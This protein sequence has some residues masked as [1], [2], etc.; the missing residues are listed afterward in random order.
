[1]AVCAL[2]V[3]LYG[4]RWLWQRMGCVLCA[5]AR[6]SL[7]LCGSG[8]VHAV[9]CLYVCLVGAH[10]RAMT[11]QNKSIA[12]QKGQ[13]IV[14]GPVLCGLAAVHSGFCSGAVCLVMAEVGSLCICVG[15]YKRV[16]ACVVTA[17]YFFTHFICVHI[18]RFGIC[19]A[20][21][22]VAVVIAVVVVFYCPVLRQ[23][24]DAE[25]KVGGCLY[26]MSNGFC[27]ALCEAMGWHSTTIYCAISLR[28]ND[29][30][31]HSLRAAF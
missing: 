16:C 1:M 25:T 24:C 12:N 22:L 21:V 13:F 3:W 7:W 29:K 4:M 8:C 14:S 6:S 15:V 5:A 2:Y 28:G 17:V 31:P 19:W 11:G 10:E 9:L 30:C 26:G 20:W 27:A 23:L 18:F